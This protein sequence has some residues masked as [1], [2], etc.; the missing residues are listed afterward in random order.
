MRAYRTSALP[1]A[2][3]SDPRALCPTLFPGGF[4]QLRFHALCPA[5]CA[6]PPSVTAFTYRPS[7]VLASAT[8]FSISAVR[9]SLC[10]ALVCVGACSRAWVRA[11]VRLSIR[12]SMCVF[13]CSYVRAPRALYPNL[14][15][16]PCPALCA[17]PHSNLFLDSLYIPPAALPS[18]GCAC[19]HACLRSCARAR[20]RA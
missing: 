12:A 9:S 13:V 6:P 5:L 8:H 18:S 20:V 15:R 19:V 17:P 16:A 10:F 4:F 3:P 14:C 1:S 2:L 11:C 7:A